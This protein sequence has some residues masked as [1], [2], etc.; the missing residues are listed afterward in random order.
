VGGVLSLVLEIRCFDLSAMSFTARTW[1]S[2]TGWW[3]SGEV[4]SKFRK[5][6]RL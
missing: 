1:D 5:V 3:F 4:V 2:A 6:I